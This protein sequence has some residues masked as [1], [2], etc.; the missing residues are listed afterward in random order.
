M[1]VFW[2]GLLCL[3]L[4]IYSPP[5]AAEEIPNLYF[6]D[7]HSQLPARQDA[8][9]IIELMDQANVYRTI[10]S[11]R[12]DRK[13]KDVSMLASQH[14]E[15]IIA[16]V[17]SKGKAFNNG[18]PKFKKLI[19]MQVNNPQYRAMGEAILYHAKKGKK[20]PEIDV[21]ANSPQ[22]QFL[23]DLAIK[24]NWP[25][26]AH[27]EFSAAGW[28]KSDYIK[29]FEAMASSHPEHPFVL[30]HMGQLDADEAKRLIDTHQNVYFIMS[31]S[32]PVTLAKNS[33]QPWANLYSGK[34]LAPEWL[35]I[36]LASPDRFIL[37]FDNVWPE[38]WGQS[39]LKQATLWRKALSE[40]PLHI[41]KA[42]AH[43][44]AERLWKLAP[45]P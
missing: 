42:L 21:A 34:S 1:R 13:P 23:L 45:K 3:Q 33:G 28:N 38:D 11:A 17:R 26:I 19:K 22:A 18:S 37:G 44:N 14:P 16:A 39:Y 25:F 36:I 27:Y 32:N 31:H 6:I 9:E 40:L 10:L 41:A 8:S 15:R 24:R 43:G 2:L 5:A 4:H 7:A 30:I 29:D 12:N 20:A 35:N